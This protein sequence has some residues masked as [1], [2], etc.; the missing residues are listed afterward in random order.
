MPSRYH[1]LS[2]IGVHIG[3]FQF[4][5]WH[6]DGISWEPLNDQIVAESG[7]RGAVMVSE[8]FDNISEMT[9]SIVQTSPNNAYI[10]A[11]LGVFATCTL[12]DKNSGTEIFAGACR[13]K[14]RPPI[15]LAQEAG[16]RAFVVQLYNDEA[17][18]GGGN[19]QII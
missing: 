11:L 2:E 10:D 9:L 12:T 7:A 3:E 18:Y 5:E 1:N 8:M 16:A 6:A 4:L 14:A 17:R 15:G 13:I 19:V